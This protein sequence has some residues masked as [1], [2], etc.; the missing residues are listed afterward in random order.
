MLKAIFPRLGKKHVHPE[1]RYAL[2]LRELNVRFNG[3]SVLEDL[4]LQIERGLSVAVVGPN[5]AG[6]STLFNVLAGLLAPA[7]GQ[8][9]VH[10]HLPAQYLCL[11]YVPQSSLVDWSFPVSVQDVVMMGRAGRLGLLRWPG[12]QDAA[13]VKRSLDRVQLSQLARRQ[14]SEL[15]GGQKQRMLLARALAQE[16]D[17]LLLDELL[18][19]LDLPS[20][21]QILGIL[22]DLKKEGITVLFATHDL[23][24]AGEHFD[25]ILLLNRKLIA[26]GTRKEVLTME[27]LALAYGGHMQVVETKEGNVWVGD[28]GGH[29]GHEVEGRH[30]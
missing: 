3:L 11:A 26:Y 13:Q 6:K 27:N 19:G 20:Q 12:R 21:E 7:S 2:E 18:A 10:G 8:V 9:H 17:L 24:L 30:G 1:S 4:S 28:I 5:G 16:A 29:H 25:R 23:E 14:I 15:S 22:G